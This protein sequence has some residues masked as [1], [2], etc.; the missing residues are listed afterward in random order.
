MSID[1]SQIAVS[2]D[3]AL[4]EAGMEVTLRRVVTGEYDP[5][6]GSAPETTV[7]YTA[8]GTVFDFK[9]QDVDGTLI[10]VG[11]QQL[12]LSP[13][14]TNGQSMPEP[15]TSDKIIIGAVEYSIQPSKKIAPAGTNVLYQLHIRGL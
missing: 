5:G 15:T 11:D 2:A 6:T 7:D 1:Y 12:F 9:Q 8:F 14:Q 10:K 3:A 13:L 4:R